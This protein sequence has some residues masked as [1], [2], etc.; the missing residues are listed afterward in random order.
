MQDLGLPAFENVFLLIVFPSL[1]V[2]E[3]FHGDET[4]FTLARRSLQS[5]RLKP[6]R[7]ASL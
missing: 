6:R 7:R 3:H 1:V 4:L 5:E 2:S